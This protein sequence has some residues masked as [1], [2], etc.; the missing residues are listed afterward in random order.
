MCTV[1]SKEWTRL[2]KCSLHCTPICRISSSKSVT[3][4]AGGC[5]E[6]V[7]TSD[8]VDVTT[9]PSDD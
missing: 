8:Y 1:K 7:H 4:E 3:V 2:Y 6:T 9:V 5:L